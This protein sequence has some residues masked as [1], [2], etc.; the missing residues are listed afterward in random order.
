MTSTRIKNLARAIQRARPGV[1]YTDALRLA[2]DKAQGKGIRAAPMTLDISLAEDVIQAKA[3]RI[4]TNR[5][6]V[7]T[8]D[9]SKPIEL[10]EW[11]SMAPSAEFEARF[12]ELLRKGRSVPLKRDASHPTTHSDP[13]GAWASFLQRPPAP[14]IHWTPYEPLSLES[15]VEASAQKMAERVTPEANRASEVS[16]NTVSDV[17]ENLMEEVRWSEMPD[18]PVNWS[19]RFRPGVRR[20]R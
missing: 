20:R 6:G 2:Q 3:E 16:G 14:V 13:L 11:H 7:E 19:L 15:V 8:P 4:A 18:L 1:K 12:N 5:G 17:V 9:P 10:D